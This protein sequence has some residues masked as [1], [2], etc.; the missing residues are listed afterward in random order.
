MGKLRSLIGGTLLGAG[1]M[2]VG[3]QYHVLLAP[4]GPVLV[5]RSPQ[6]SL[7]EAFADIQE[8]DAEMW[9][10]HPQISLAVQE[11]G[12]LDLINPKPKPS[13][14]E[15]LRGKLLP[16]REQS[17][18]SNSGWEP[19][20]TP[21]D[22]VPSAEGKIASAGQDPE[23]TSRKRSFLPLAELFGFN[24]SPKESNDGRADESETQGAA[25]VVPTGTTSPPEVELLPPPDE[26]DM[27]QP[28]PLPRNYPTRWQQ[29]DA[30]E[31][32]RSAYDDQKWIPLTALP[33]DG[34]SSW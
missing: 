11:H 9:A 6:H 27:R 3:L 7:K 28:I 16:T 20:V 5:P 21:E 15:N 34:G 2:Y 1:G 13:V 19:L 12:R 23:K 24:S 26:A 17:S 30:D 18:T 29:S 14:L 32:Q 22:P 33:D 10:A 25:A 31:S 4:E 8:W